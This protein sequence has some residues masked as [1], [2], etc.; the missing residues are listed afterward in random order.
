MHPSIKLNVDWIFLFFSHVIEYSIGY[1]RRWPGAV[2]WMECR[3]TTG[4][5]FRRQP[6][7]FQRVP[8]SKPIHRP[9][10]KTDTT[11]VVTKEVDLF[12]WGHNEHG[13]AFVRKER[14]LHPTHVPFDEGPI[15]TV[16]FLS[17]ILTWAT[18][19]RSDLDGQLQLIYK[20]CILSETQTTSSLILLLLPTLT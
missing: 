6:R 16:P 7:T 3:R 9:S 20:Q 18:M 13:Q 2:V 1:V 17:P 8:V 19:K 11:L 14:D 12:T 4:T 15:R 10:C 5:L